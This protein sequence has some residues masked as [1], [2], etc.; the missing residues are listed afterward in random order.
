MSGIQDSDH[1]DIQF[2]T[3]PLAL[4]FGLLAVIVTGVFVGGIVI[5]RGMT[6]GAPETVV[7]QRIPEMAPS[8]AASPE[9]PVA[10]DPAPS[11]PG[12][13]GVRL[14]I[15]EGT[16]GEA[17]APERSEPASESPEQLSRRTLGAAARPAPRA[18]GSAAPA[19]RESGRFTI[20]V[21]A[22]RE[23][24]AA[25]AMLERLA[26][27]GVEGYLEGTPAGI[28]RVRVGNFESREAAR[29]VAARLENDEFPTLVTSR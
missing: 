26:E 9:A 11:P 29:E 21:A 4:L 10:G 17:P 3:R 27:K 22:F 20:Q 19:G 12:A 5:G 7:A 23:R 6:P 14:P 1:Y 24:A 18:T 15:S 8:P 28:F 13:A 25:E 2:T 16:G